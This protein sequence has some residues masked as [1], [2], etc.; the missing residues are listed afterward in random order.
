MVAGRFTQYGTSI[1]V[2]SKHGREA[3]KEPATCR[4]DIDTSREAEKGKAGS[5]ITTSSHGH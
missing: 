5:F 1:L 4:R 2:V 3:K